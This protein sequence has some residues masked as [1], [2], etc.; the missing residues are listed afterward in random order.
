VAEGAARRRL[1]R[2]GLSLDAPHDAEAARALLGSETWEFVT[3]RR[4][5]IDVGAM[6]P[7]LEA[8]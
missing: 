6:L 5:T 7:V 1:A 8:R 2:H 4:A 3:R